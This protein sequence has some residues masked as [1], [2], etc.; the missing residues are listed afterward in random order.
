M[1]EQIKRA[2]AINGNVIYFVSKNEK[3]VPY[4]AVIVQPDGDYSF[5]RPVHDKILKVANPTG[6]NITAEKFFENS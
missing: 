2:E 4:A 6:K 5:G 1:M 3:G